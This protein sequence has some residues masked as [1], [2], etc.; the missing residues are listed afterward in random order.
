MLT[1]TGLPKFWTV[2]V[3]GLISLLS[4]KEVLSESKLQGKALESSLNMA[5]IP[6]F[7]SFLAIIVYQIAEIL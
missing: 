2:T 3:V 7:I 5:I 4:F 6:L 1:A